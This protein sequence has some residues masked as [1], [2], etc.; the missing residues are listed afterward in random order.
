MRCPYSVVIWLSGLLI[1]G[2][3]E[4]IQQADT[5]LFQGKVITVDR[6][7]SIQHAV[8]IKNGKILAVGNN[9]EILRLAGTNTRKINLNGKTV[10]P[11]V[12]EGHVHPVSASQLEY[13]QPVPDIRSIQELLEW[14]YHEAGEKAADGWIIHPKFFATRLSEMRMPTKSELDSIA[15]DHPVFL[16]GSY[17]GM[18]NSK[19]LEISGLDAHTDHPGVL[20]SPENG[21]PTGFIRRSAFGLLDLPENNGLTR[22]K[23][24]ELL[25]NLLQLYN[26]AG[27]TSVCVGSG[28]PEDLELFEM[29]KATGQLPVRVFQNMY[30]PFDPHASL[31]EMRAVL[32]SFKYV[33][34][35]GDEWVKVGALKTHVDGGIL[36]GTAYL[37]EPW[38]HEAFEIYGITDPAYRGI[39]NLNKQELTRIAS[40]A[41]ELGWKFTAHITGGGGVD[42]FLSALEELNKISPINGKRFSVIHGN[43]YTA[44]AIRKMT[45]MGVYADMQPAWFY[46]DADLLYRVLGKERMSAFHPY[47]SL[48]EAGVVVNGG[49]DH[50]VRLDSYTSINPYNPFVAMWS[51]VT[52]KT[53]RGSIYEVDEAISREQ[54]LKMYTINNAYASFEEDI[55]GS[56]EPGKLADMVVLSEDILTCPPDHIKDIEALLTM[57]NGEVV[58][59]RKGY[60]P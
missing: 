53:E 23:K 37:R 9:E 22:Q 46:K 31:N 43:F 8:A 57:V 47:R 3:N 13:Y 11:G 48:F 21:E 17:G 50:M 1:W 12:N 24:L 27:I 49:S 19:A 14:I 52:R 42:E 30:I 41:N 54:A 40:V 7:F 51:I 6:E 60:L 28:G 34:G 55:K 5:V 20:K 26:R 2:C 29:L 59:E 32:G 16:D 18:V 10:I 56:I 33:T 58:Y 36:T 44:K 15:P 39:L 4:E 38:G 45:E 35:D 25:R